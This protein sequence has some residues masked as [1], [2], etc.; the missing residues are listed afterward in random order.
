MAKNLGGRPRKI[1]SPKAMAEAWEE[2]KKTCDENTTIKT[3][4]SSSASD[5]ITKV[6]P[7]PITY[8]IEGF[9]VH[10]GINRTVFYDTYDADPRFSDIVKKIRLECEIDM[11][12]KFE[13]GTIPTALAALWASKYGYSTKTEQNIQGSIPV[14]V[15]DIKK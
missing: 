5:F 7:S 3:Q 12:K 2:F 14:I 6:V 4:F 1:A 10:L 8:T 11:R 13:T 15:D 9:C